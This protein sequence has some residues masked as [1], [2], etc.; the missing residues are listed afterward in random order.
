MSAQALARARLI[1]L[2][3]SNVALGLRAVLEAA[4]EFLGAPL[5]IFAAIGLGRS[6][7]QRSR[8]L[9]RELPGILECGIWEALH[10]RPALPG[11]A[12]IADVGNDVGYGVEPE[13]IASWI[14]ECFER[15]EG[16]AGKAILI[17]PPLPS[18]ASCPRWRFAA[19]RALLFPSCRLD[20]GEVL[21][22]LEALDAALRGL[23]DSRGAAIVE[24]PR[25][26][27]GL[28]PIHIRRA[29]RRSA[30]RK[31][32]ESWGPGKGDPAPPLGAGAF[33]GLRLH[34]ELYWI[35]GLERRRRQPAGAFRDGTA[36]WL[37]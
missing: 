2:G 33:V 32:L 17:L 29:L 4:R 9:G 20:R 28:D 25:E 34:P 19:A 14:S 18:I 21:Q 1:L 6:Y 26:W 35:F 3:A 16:Q 36:M 12:L 15:L 11:Y 30:W 23:A 27:Y 24:P 13:K 37:Y 22:R 7:G 5:E 8:V 31:A 10:S